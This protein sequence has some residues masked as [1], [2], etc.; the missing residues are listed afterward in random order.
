MVHVLLQVSLSPHVLEPAV[1]VVP[2]RQQGVLMEIQLRPSGDEWIYTVDRRLMAAS[3][4]WLESGI[5]RLGSIPRGSGRFG[6]V[7]NGTRGGPI[8]DTRD[9]PAVVADAN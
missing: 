7:T 2:I 6:L 9:E 4:Q 3:W 1:G 5:E 8:H